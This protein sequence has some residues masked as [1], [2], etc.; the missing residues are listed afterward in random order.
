MRGSRGSVVRASRYIRHIAVGT[1]LVFGLTVALP[2]GTPPGAGGFPVSWL[3]SW[4]RPTA[5]S[6]APVWPDVPGVPRQPSGTAAGKRHYVPTDATTADGG[7]GRPPGKGIG[8]LAPYSPQAPKVSQT[9]TPALTG[10]ITTTDLTTTDFTIMTAVPPQVDAQYPPAGYA[11]PTLTPELLVAAHDPDASPGTMT[12]DFLVYN[13]AGTKIADSGW[14]TSRTWVVPAGKLVWGQTYSWTVGAKDGAALLSTSQRLNSLATPVPQPLITSGLAQNDGRGFEPSVG[15]YTTT[16]TDATVMAVG[17]ALS[18]ERAY[19]SQDPRVGLAFGAGWSSVFDAKVTEQKDV[20]GALQTAVATYPGGQE[21]AFG[22]NADGTFASPSGRFATFASVTG[23]YRLV[24]KDG[25]TYTFTAA[26]GVPGQFGLASIAD[27]QGRTATL[28]YDAGRPTKITS[29]SGRAL[30]LTWSTP[31]GATVP[32]VATVVTDPVSAGD[33]A[34]ALT[35]TYTYS[36]DLLTKVCPPTSSTAC[37]SYGYGTAS[38]HPSAVDNAGPRS[39]WR[40]GDASGTAATSAVLDN[41]GTD[42]GRYT[43]VTLGQPGPLPGSTATASG[44]NGT[45]SRVQVP[46]KLVTNG[47]YQAISLWFKTTAPNGVLFSYQADPI[48][49]PTTPGNYTPALYVGASGKLYGE[50]W[51]AGGVAPMASA[52][53]VTD[54]NWHHVVLSAAGNTQSLYLD[55]ALVGSKTGLIQMVNAA[56]AANMYIGAGFIG[57]GWP[58]ESH[59]QQSGNTGYATFFNGTIGEVGFFDRPLTAANVTAVH[60][61][62]RATAHPLT[63]IVRPS[64]NP[65]ATIA[66]DPK[67][68]SVTQ[69]TDSNGGVWRIA[70]PTVSGSSQVY[71]GAALAAGPVDYWRLSE[72]GTIDAINEVNG[73][74]ATYSS[75]TLGVTGGPLGDATVASFNGTSSYLRLPTQDVPTTGPASISMWFKMPANNTAGGVLFGY[76]N[77]PVTDPT[78]TTSWVPALY[79]GTDGKLRGTYWVGD[80]SKIITS[81]GRVNDGN[82]HHVALAASTGSQSLYLDGV[83][84]APPVSA[85]L[86]ATSAQYAYVGA[87]KWSGS[88]PAHSAA[89][90]GYFPGQIGEVAYYRAQLSNAQVAAQFAAREKSSGAPVRTIVVTDPGN[91]TITH[92]YDVA[93]GREIAET[94]ALGN[95]TQYGYD[96]G[97]FLR[98]I[99]DPNGNVTTSEHDV[100]GNV[101]SQTTC[102]DRSANRCST[103]YYTYYPDATTKVLTPDP[104]N[105][106]ML[107]MRDGRSASAT[108]NTYLTSYT[109]DVKGNRTAI[110]DPLGR[111]TATAYTDGTTVAAADGGLAP[112]GLPMTVTTPSGDKQSVVYYRSGEVAS[113]TDPAGKVTRFTYDGLGRVLSETETTDTFPAGLTTQYA[114]DGL[115]RVVSQTDPAT[116]NRVTGAAH[117]AVT[118]TVYNV[119]GQVTSQTVSDTTGGDAARTES[120]TYNTHGQQD[121]VTD[122][123]GNVSRYEYDVYGNVVKETEVDGGIT[124]STYD[125]EGN[126]LTSTVVGY[127]GDPNAPSAPTDLVV[128]SK[129]YDPAGRLASVTDAMGW[130]ASYTYTDNELTATV[131]R[132]DPTSGATFTTEQDSY[133][134]AGNLVRQ[135]TNNGATTVT[136]TVDAADRTVSSTLDPDGLGRTTTLE[137]SRDDDV[138]SRTMSDSSGTVAREETLFDKLGRPL[139]HAVHNGGLAPLAR[140]RLAEPSGAQTARD[141]GGNSPATATNVTWTTDHGGAAAFN[142]TNSVITTTGPVVDTAR[143][144]TFAAWVYP[145]D[146]STNR[147]V[148]T[149][150]GRTESSFNLK[151]D[152]L[153]SGTWAM[154][155]SD[156]DDPT[157]GGTYVRSPQPAQLNTWTH[158]AGVFD[159]AAGQMRLY[160]N[161]A[162]AATQALPAGFVP[163]TATG[164]LAI[165]RVKWHGFLGDYFAGSVS[166]VQAYSRVLTAAEISGV[167]GGTAPAAGAGVIRTSWVRDQD[168][169]V[170]SSIDPLGQATSYE[171]DEDGERVVTV[172]PAVQ[173]ET[174]GGA[175]V[176]TRPVTFAGYNTF[177]EHVEAKDPNGNVTVAGYDAAGRVVSTR[178]PSY[179]PPG[180]STPITPETTATYDDNGQLVS[181]TDALGRTTTYVYDQLGR[182]AKATAPNLGVTRYTYDLLGDQLSVTDPNGA[183]ASATYDFLG[184]QVTSTQAVRQT[185]TSHTTRYT[186][187]PG[188][189]LSETRSPGD[190]VTKATYNAAGETLTSTDGANAVTSYAYDG[191]GRPVRT[192]LVDGTYTTITYDMAGRDIATRT[193]DAAG[194]LLATQSTEYDAAN[195]VTA[196]TDARTTR[197]TFAYDSTGMV[198]SE[199]QPVS[200]T[201]SITTSFG[202]DVS[203]NRTRF[204]DG[205]GNA[206]LTTY[207]SWG[208]PESKIEP[209]TPAY[210]NLADRTFTVSYNA[211]GQVA[212]QTSPGGVSV[213]NTYDVMGN[214]TRQVGAGAEV[215]TADR[216]F[217]YDLG[218]RLVSASAPGGTNTF[219]YDDRNLLLSTAGPSGDA[220]FAYNA[221]GSMTSRADAAGPTSYT[222]DTAG[223]VS[224]VVNPTTGVQLGY[225]YNPLSLVSSVTYG[226]T[227]NART[228]GYD[229]RHRL[230]SDD[231]RTPAGTSIAKITYGYDSN[232]NETS[233]TTTGFAGSSANTYS[234]DRADRLILW[235]DGTTNTNYTYDK[236][237]NRTSVGSKT[238]SYDQRNQLLT[239]DGTSFGYTPRGTLSSATSGSATYLT[240]TDAFGQVIRQDA[241]SG[242]QNYTYDA[243][244]RLLRTGFAYSGLGNTLAA[245]GAAKYTRDEDDDLVG[246]AAGASQTH[247][248]TDQHTDV[249]GLLTATGT[250][251]TGSTTYDPLGRIVATNGMLGNLGYQS[252]WTD[253]STGRVNMWNRWY[254][255][256]T[257]QFDTR[258]SVDLDPVPDSV[259]ANRFAY[260]DDN[261]LTETDPTGHWP[262]CGWCKKAVSK[263]SSAW[264]A[265]TSFVSYS[266]SYA[267]SYARSYT[268][269]AYHYAART[270]HAAKKTVSHAYR[271]VQ[272]KVSHAY[273]KVRRWANHTYH[274]AK[275]WV[276]HRYHA[277]TR[278]VKHA[279]HAAHRWV[280]HAYHKARKWVAHKVHTVRKAIKKAYHRVKQAG[281]VVVAR[282]ARVVKHVAHKVK[283]AYNA[284]EKWV[285]DHKNA[286]IEA[287]AIGG[288]I[289]AGIACTAA[290]AGAGAVACMVGTA[291]IINLAK[292]AAQGNIHNWGDA[293]QSL[294]TGA[295]QGLAGGAS[296]AIGGKAA[297]FVAGKMGKLAGSVGG[298]MLSGAV[299]GGVGDAAYQLGTTG[300]VNLRG[301]AVSAGISAALG[302]V[303][304]GRSPSGCTHSFDRK[305]KVLLASGAT[306]AIA[307]VKIGDRV[308]ATDPRTGQ[309]TPQTVVALHLN[310]DTDLT[311]L[312]VRNR[313]GETEVLHTTQHHPFWDASRKAWVD[314]KDLTASRSTLV[315]PDGGSLAL[316]S[317]RNYTDVKEM[318]DL[319]VAN[320]HT[321]YV[322]AAGQP[323]L[324]HNC[325]DGG[326]GVSVTGHDLYVSGSKKRPEPAWRNGKEYEL[327][328]DGKV[329]PGARGEDG[330]P[331][332]ISTN[333]SPSGVPRNSSNTH[334]YRLPAGTTL[335]AGMKVVADGTDA[336]GP[337]PLGHHTFYP[338]TA[339]S[340]SDFRGDFRG[341]DGWENLGPLENF[342]V[343]GG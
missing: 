303:Y 187:G 34:S 88:W 110:T 281:K 81:P 57:G 215:A 77:G 242:T 102:Q 315:A 74:T 305:T 267:Y 55:G 236:S 109:Y 32:H 53:S 229:S 105:D 202:Y 142:G 335:P 163:W 279:Y 329:V 250:A 230:V 95:K 193:Y 56:S 129:A 197:I 4:L 84:V 21:I 319:T 10:D 272:K 231:L 22:R 318:H 265:T 241:A 209:A 206:F 27:A 76:Q 201:Q 116:T 180:S 157:S 170:E 299:S 199:T 270:Y 52:G 162:L 12:Y 200:A 313:R 221:D 328:G 306:V 214:L 280:K 198:V 107:T 186:Y 302:G 98:T 82:W 79:V 175:P 292:D 72:T 141:S 36:G 150:E 68:G 219:A 316:L 50:F 324:V 92:V 45:S 104:R 327:D 260:A 243:L 169:L 127:T 111:V 9:T 210:P 308:K 122:P 333:T 246:V 54:G 100:R 119:D 44:F 39:Y 247:A 300:K 285:K 158:V 262:S 115:G 263:V 212:S 73:N 108:D 132:R 173:A 80:L 24:D 89:A 164:P 176:A 16:A 87:G 136:Y 47:S 131:V 338:T 256:L 171:Y 13:S 287:V 258:D 113:V 244:G 240:Q 339:V 238:F 149:Q 65:S 259:D 194:V 218:G 283:D 99:T 60:N 15:N 58:D 70:A 233:K 266:Y 211:V 101:V 6:A 63:S 64:G 118:T 124:T 78:V 257:G 340:P 153:A 90:V 112:P 295:I 159:A 185:G 152:S 337:G 322:V 225:G 137:Y 7:A 309:T 123:A 273:H 48:S 274:A 301:V 252:S 128:T 227:G 8:A 192:T 83:P 134:A 28:T 33:P 323:A 213:T 155:M 41:S 181:S 249:V 251:L 217:D 228:V 188:G 139:A 343:K 43:N 296:G 154:S 189:W 196:A 62:G 317:V 222:Y 67:T 232:G 51:Y 223:R 284:T 208:L 269:Y 38:R 183:T 93:T 20:A 239:G 120:A 179:T 96:V 332:G 167:Y 294:G 275:R 26:T 220:T 61:T 69:V 18:V 114:Y 271:A 19:N 17:P 91:K 253:F 138:V 310:R 94:D 282:T 182:L 235:Y 75:V 334:L 286:I 290:T 261:P 320:V 190:I 168:G 103:V 14:I 106:V 321:Y 277:A 341:L 297:G 204:T 140:W 125:A 37:T 23:G 307:N 121:T 3:W 30:T 151:V 278:W 237:G 1:T 314:A 174:G 177:G 42:N 195:N 156:T 146:S 31:A 147:S 325:G 312:V 234:Y 342:P 59:Y 288:A 143:S 191:A 207:N 216:T 66:Y 133:D 2:A 25:T 29:A 49:N 165:G 40:L 86:V 117:T 255:T 5:A 311:D 161:G 205:R 298:R 330:W 184:R 145:T 248:W 203:G 224:T 289:L 226:S 97:G 46:S 71:A 11:S 336:G 268:S 326:E 293:F 245:D 178:L 172:S 304:R 254:N 144:F 276:K 166:D 264:H 35:W 148:L 331:L 160:L 85:P 130:V 135:L 291:A 126:L